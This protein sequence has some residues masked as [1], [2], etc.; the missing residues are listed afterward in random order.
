MNKYETLKSHMNMALK[1]GQKLR[2]LTLADI[3]ATIDKAA[4]SGKTRVEI[5]DA[6]VDEILTKYQKTVQE[7][8][9][10]CPNSEK[11]AGLKAEYETKLEIVKGYAPQLISDEETIRQMVLD[12]VNGEYPFEK[13]SRGP[14][15]KLVMPALKGKADMAVANKVI[16]EMLN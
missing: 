14:I 2:R 13:K 16:G 6:F 12:A 11:Y 4:T 10:T 1:D 3:V 7:M 5:T 8:I 15:M 9:D